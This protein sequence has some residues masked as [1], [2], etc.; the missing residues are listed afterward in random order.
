MEWIIVGKMTA[1]ING[2]NLVTIEHVVISKED[3]ADLLSDSGF[4]GSSSI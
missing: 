3:I 1:D 4:S 2:L